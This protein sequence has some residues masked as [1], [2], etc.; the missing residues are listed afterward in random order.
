[1]FLTI[2]VCVSFVS[3]ALLK[4]LLYIIVKTKNCQ[5]QNIFKAYIPGNS[6]VRW[7]GSQIRGYIQWCLIGKIL[8]NSTSGGIQ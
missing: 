1:M 5:L 3:E 7:V 2:S 4:T 8:K 6:Q